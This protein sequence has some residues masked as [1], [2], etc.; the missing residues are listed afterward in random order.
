MAGRRIRLA[1]VQQRARTVRGLVP[2]VVG[3]LGL[4]MLIAAG[5]IF[6]G[7]DAFAYD[8]EAYFAAA[9]R[10][11]DGEPLY[12]PGTTEAYRAGEYEGL[13][14]Y[15]PPVAVAFLPLALLDPETAATA[16]FVALLVMLAG[17]CALMPVSRA[18]RLTTFGLATFSYAV[19]SD[20]NLG[21]VSIA[22]FA[23]T[24]L[25]WRQADRPVA[26]VAHVALGLLRLPFG[27]F[28]IMWLFQG[29]WRMIVLTIGAGVVIVAI[30]LPI[31]GV[32]TYREYF[33]TLTSL[34][35]VS[36]GEHNFSF[37]SIAI[38][39]GLGGGA[40]SAALLLQILLGVA[41]IGFASLRR[42]R[43]TAFVVTAVATLLIAPFLHPHYLV[44]LLVPTAF[45]F[46]R[47]SPLAV[48]LPLLGWLPGN[49]L[50]VVA[51]A[52]I[53]VL[54]L[55]TVARAQRRDRPVSSGLVAEPT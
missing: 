39:L 46:D 8:F 3:G 30:S 11:L 50:P 21:N 31:V 16:W 51:V 18:A 49:L 54:L 28:G 47:L 13:Y 36:T 38:E 25:A 42:D 52:T 40:A 14:L 43:D 44:I 41:A 45:L 1:T 53:A 20:L 24:A 5:A 2:F 34:P 37:K 10:I 23:L 12:L 35:D 9:R 15:P 33:T 48:G 27:A 6:M 22:T 17:G 55:P 32:D 29:R 4:L 7:G 19:L 26:S